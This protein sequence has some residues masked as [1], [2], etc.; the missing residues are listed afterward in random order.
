MAQ[1]FG[2]V[3]III[4]SAVQILNVKFSC[5][6]EESRPPFAQRT[7]DI[8]SEGRRFKTTSTAGLQVASSKNIR[9]NIGTIFQKYRANIGKMVKL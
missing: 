5:Q 1:A 2:V 6:Y 4:G 9:L 8:R 7:F 3:E